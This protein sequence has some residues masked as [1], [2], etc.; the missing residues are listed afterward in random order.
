[1][2][3]FRNKSFLYDSFA[4]NLIDVDKTFRMSVALTVSF[5]VSFGQ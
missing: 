4:I 3:L 1:M 2:S 5:A